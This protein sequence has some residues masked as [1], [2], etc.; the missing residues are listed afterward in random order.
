MSSFEEEEKEKVVKNIVRQNCGTEEKMTE[1]K[2]KD[3][4]ASLCEGILSSKAR[5]PG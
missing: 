4:M 3:K 5:D 1:A 2:T